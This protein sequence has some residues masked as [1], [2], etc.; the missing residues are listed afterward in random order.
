MENTYSYKI[1]SLYIECV[2]EIFNIWAYLRS[3]IKAIF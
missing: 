2:T 3:N 1:D